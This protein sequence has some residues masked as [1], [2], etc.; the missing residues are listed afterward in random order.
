MKKIALALGLASLVGLTSSVFAST[1]EKTTA[2]GE[3]IVG[4]AQ[5]TVGDITGNKKMQA[6]GTTKKLKGDL[7]STKES[8]KDKAKDALN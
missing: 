7:R 2:A 5:S 1:S 8:I 6:K 4:S 3:Q